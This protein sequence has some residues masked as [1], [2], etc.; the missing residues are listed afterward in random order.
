MEKPLIIKKDK[1]KE[2]PPVDEKSSILT[3]TI[4]VGVTL[5]IAHFVM[6]FFAST[7]NDEKTQNITPIAT[8]STNTIASPSIEEKAVDVFQDSVSKQ[9]TGPVTPTYQRY[10][11]QANLANVYSVIT[12]VKMHI[13]TYYQMHGEFPKTN[14]DIDLELFDLTEHQSINSA[15]FNKLAV[16][17][18]G[19]SESFG[20]SKKIFLKPSTSKNGA[21]IK[22]DCVTNIDKKLLVNNSHL[23]RHSDAI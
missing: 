12:P 14:E 21:F 16:L 18:I 20:V 3:F 2:K 1:A 9:A 11:S 13:A 4:G 19:L 22:W 10:Y 8:S 15:Q 23:C 5:V 7:P 6:P 17:E